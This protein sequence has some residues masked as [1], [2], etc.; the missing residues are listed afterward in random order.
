MKSI[1]YFKPFADWLTLSYSASN[2][3][4]S[5]ILAFLCSHGLGPELSKGPQKSLFQHP[6]GGTLFVT[7]KDSY[8]SF[9]FSGSLLSVI[10]QA[11]QLSDFV[12]VLAASPHNITRLDAA[13]DVPIDGS[14]ALSNIEKLYPDG[15]AEICGHTRSVLYELS[16]S[17]I[18]GRK[19]G[20]AYFQNSKY[21][22][23]VRLCAYDKTHQAHEALGLLLPPTF[24]YELRIF[25]GASLR[26]FIDPSDMFWH[27]MPEKLVKRPESVS[28]RSWSPSERVDYDSVEKASPTDYETLRFLI[29]NSVALRGLMEKA[30]AVNGGVSLLHREIDSY[31]ESN[32]VQ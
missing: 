27:Y 3:P 4:Y 18:N 32:L 24:R 30:S 7:C 29:Q 10:R 22:G 15:K 25:R 1:D 16:T 26:D 31:L 12:Q 11:G 8:H 21:K 17:P 2:S 23:N 13:Y 19:T 14:I 20:T 28:V 6:D 9:S 5:E